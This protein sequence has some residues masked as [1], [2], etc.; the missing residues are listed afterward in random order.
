M[1]LFGGSEWGEGRPG[2][3]KRLGHLI[4]FGPAP[5]GYVLRKLRAEDPRLAQVRITVTGTLGSLARTTGA[6]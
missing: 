5:S 3:M 4:L 2:A 6:G 1:V